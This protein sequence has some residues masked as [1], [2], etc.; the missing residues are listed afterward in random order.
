MPL[1]RFAHDVTRTTLLAL[2]GF[3]VL[4]ILV[5][6]FGGEFP[7]LQAIAGVTPTSI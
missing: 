4:H 7:A 3:A 2:V 6:R 1:A 5:K